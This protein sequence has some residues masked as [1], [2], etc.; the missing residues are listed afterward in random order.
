[1]FLL[2]ALPDFKS[3][4]L[5]FAECDDELRP[6]ECR[7]AIRLAAHGRAGVVERVDSV[8]SEYRLSVP[9]HPKGLA[10]GLPVAGERKRV[11]GRMKFDGAM[12]DDQSKGRRPGEPVT[13]TRDGARRTVPGLERPG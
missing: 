12:G 11:C 5:L 13:A 4:M 2:S 6:R 10:A 3:A 8:W 1:Y 9:D 7:S